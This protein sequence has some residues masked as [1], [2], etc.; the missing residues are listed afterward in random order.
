MAGL[1]VASPQAQTVHTTV[2][3]AVTV[4]APMEAVEVWIRKNCFHMNWNHSGSH[5]DSGAARTRRLEN[6]Y[7]S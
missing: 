7:I 2:T 3:V 1:A 4:V 6:T 5:S